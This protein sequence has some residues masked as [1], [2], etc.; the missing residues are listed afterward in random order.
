MRLTFLLLQQAREERFDTTSWLS[1]DLRDT[2]ELVVVKIYE[3]IFSKYVAS[4]SSKCC[5][6]EFENC[7]FIPDLKVILVS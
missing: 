5:A 1:A 2:F 7:P 3:I 4:V 6:P